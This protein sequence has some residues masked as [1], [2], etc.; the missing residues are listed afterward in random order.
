MV[1]V[2]LD[3]IYLVSKPQEVREGHLSVER[4]LWRHAKTRVMR[5]RRTWGTLLPPNQEMAQVAKHGARVWRG[6]EVPTEKQGI[7]VLGAPKGHRVFIRTHL[8]K[9]QVQHQALSP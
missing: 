1:M 3:V 2:F 9:V 7:K 4:E 5:R 6:S 8:Q